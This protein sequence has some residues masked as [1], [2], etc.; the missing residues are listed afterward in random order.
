[1]QLLFES[2]ANNLH[3]LQERA[4]EGFSDAFAA[5]LVLKSL[6]DGSRNL[7]LS[8]NDRCRLLLVVM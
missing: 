3:I 4:T 8:V 1:M 2:L 5:E 7:M 6:I